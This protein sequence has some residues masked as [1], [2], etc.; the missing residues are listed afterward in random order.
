MPYPACSPLGMNKS[1]DIAIIGPGKVGVAIGVL[2]SKAGWTVAALGG[3][4]PER[5]AEAAAVIGPCAG[6]YGGP[7]G[8]G[9]GAGAADHQR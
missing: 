2:A 6:H 4:N 8:W 1:S 3:R 7:G 9:G 5:T